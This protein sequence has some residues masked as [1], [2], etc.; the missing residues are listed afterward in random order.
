MSLE[1]VIAEY[2]GEEVSA[3]EAYSHI[4]HLGEGYGQMSMEPAGEFKANPLVYYKNDFEKHGHYRILFE[5]EFESILKVAQEADFAII[6]GCT[7]FGRKN[8]QENASKLHTFIFDLDYVDDVTL[9]RFLYG[10]TVKEYLVYPRPNYIA[11]SGHNIHLYYVLENPLD[12]F[13]EIK[14]KAK[15]LKYGLIKA[16]WNG[17]TSRE[18]QP[19]F[20]GINQGFRV[21]G[22]KCKVDAPRKTIRVFKLSDHPWSIRGLCEYV[23]EESRFEETERFKPGRMTFE[24]AKKKYPEWAKA[25]EEG[26]DDEIKRWKLEEKVH[27]DDPYALYHWWKKRVLTEARYGHRYFAVMVLAIDAMQCGFPYE[28]LVQECKDD[29]LDFL[30]SIRP[31]FPFTED[32]LMSALE[33]YDIRYATYPTK[34][35]SRVSAIEIKPNKRNYRVQK[36]HIKLMNFIRD[37]INHNTT[38]NKIGN[39]R[40][41]KE[42][43]VKDWQLH[44]PT[45]TKAECARQT[46]LDPKTIRK[47]WKI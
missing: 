25:I 37:E 22:G 26:R 47:W 14:T 18:K 38:W 15:E 31:D 3:M 42:S 6:S 1:S 20:Q 43:V 29:L 11:L 19:Q 10:T 32:D 23:P 16:I 34:E 35:K 8:L 40:R 2:G 12:L 9:G 39:G 17:N 45:G 27:G 33:C 28:K 46:G 21:L 4:F 30:T 13:P 5:D 24:E 7:Y 44:N 41:N 36:D